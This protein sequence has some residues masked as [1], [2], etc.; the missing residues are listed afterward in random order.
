MSYD[1]K[2]ENCI[3]E[4]IFSLVFFSAPFALISGQIQ[5]WVNSIVSYDFPSTCNTNVFQLI[6]DWAKQVQVWK[7]KKYGPKKNL[8]YIIS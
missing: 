8:A 4:D 6:Q 1:C 3:Q 7:D 2:Q 5:D